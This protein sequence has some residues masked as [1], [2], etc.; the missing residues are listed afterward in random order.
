MWAELDSDG[1]GSLDM[2]ELADLMRLLFPKK[3]LKQEKLI[4]TFEKLDRDGSGDL[5]KDEFMVWWRKQ[6]G[7]ARRA[8]AQIEKIRM[9]WSIHDADRSGELERGELRKV[10]APFPFIVV[11][12]CFD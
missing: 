1:S 10:G 11:R 12:A 9:L 3:K 6:K 7:S 8:A 2:D 4:K 5:D